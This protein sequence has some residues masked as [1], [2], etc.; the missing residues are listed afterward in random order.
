MK[1]EIMK[2]LTL[3]DHEIM[4]TLF[5]LGLLLLFSFIFGM[6]FEFFKAPKVVGE[7]FGGMI[8]GGSCLYL[9]MPG[10]MDQIFF[11][12]EAEG[13]VLNIFYQLGLIFLMF[14]S[15]YSTRLEINK[16]NSRLFSCLFV[17][18]T[19]LP[20]LAAIP[21]I[22]VFS[23]D[24]IGSADSGIAFDMVFLIGV[25][26]TS[27]PVISKIFFDL[28]M[29][30][31]RFANIVLTAST[32]QDLCLWIFLNT[33]IQ[34]ASTNEFYLLDMVAFDCMTIGLLLGVVIVSRFVRRIRFIIPEKYFLQSCFIVMFLLIGALYTLRINVMYSAFLVGYLMQSFSAH[35]PSAE[36]KVRS[37]KDIS[38]SLFVPVYFA[39]VGVQLNVIHNISIGRFLLFFALAF[40]LEGLG[41]G[42]VLLFT[43]LKRGAVLNFAV[44]MNARGGPGIVLATTAYSYNIINIEFFT[45]LILTTML[46]SL[47]AG[48]WLRRQ[49]AK[50]ETIFC[51]LEKV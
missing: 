44:T 13:R 8:L 48:Y 49:K 50:D 18:S 37:I 47:I 10:A 38:F 20:M 42:I 14:S 41:T 40:I 12:Y 15:G 51:D 28:G 7:I 25:A 26:I 29:M 35:D 43:N 2:L 32:L 17:G 45:V 36:E 1:G 4:M 34:I 22:S 31:T 23:K 6:L 3:T 46:S 5:A 21:F 39:L 9:L 19:V 33:A 27:I 30:Q 16:G 24:F 11:A